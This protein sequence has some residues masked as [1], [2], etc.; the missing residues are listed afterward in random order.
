MRVAICDDE[1]C[2]VEMIYG[3]LWNES[4][5]MIDTYLDAQ[6]LWTE[7]QSGTRYDV[8]FCDIMMQPLNGIE[9]ARKIR[10]LDL[11]VILVYLT[12][13][14]DFAPLGYEVRAFRYL[15][16]PIHREALL[17]V[18]KD[19]REEQKK[20]KKLLFETTIGS[21]LVPENTIQYIEAF[22]KEIQIFYNDDS[23]YIKKGLNEMEDTLTPLCFFRIHRKYLIHLDHVL[24]YDS[25][26]V[27]LECGKTLPISRRKSKIF[28]ETM[29][30]FIKGEC[31]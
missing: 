17:S 25:S 15:L 7:Y 1:A 3:Y 5:C 12:S 18:M 31:S 11:D 21:I 9:L 14:L 8:I 20:E 27:T 29:E 30:A 2:F 4:S 22:D 24:E 23:F 28:R 10:T 26:K 13:N 19:I 6:E 16:K